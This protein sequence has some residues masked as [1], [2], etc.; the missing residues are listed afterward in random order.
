MSREKQSL[1][2]G[3]AASAQAV[4]FAGILPAP[5]ANNIE[6]VLYSLFPETK[7]DRPTIFVGRPYEFDMY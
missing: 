1:A 6:L 5:L 4:T 3:T 2:W 7:K